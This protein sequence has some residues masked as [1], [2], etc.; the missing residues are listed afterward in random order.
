M[1]AFYKDQLFNQACHHPAGPAKVDAQFMATALAVY[2]T[3]QNLAGTVAAGYGFHVTDTGL[4]DRVVNVGSSGAAFGAA[5]G[6][7]RTVM[8]LLQATNAMTHGTGAGFDYVYDVNGDGVVDASEAGL[9]LQ[10]NAMYASINNAGG[11]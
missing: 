1:A 9:R 7:T 2:F 5:N 6:T 10:A 4:G 3:D 8:Q 11:I